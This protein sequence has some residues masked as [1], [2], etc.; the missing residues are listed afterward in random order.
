VSVRAVAVAPG[1]AL[2]DGDSANRINSLLDH[3]FAQLDAQLI[4]RG[5][6]WMIYEPKFLG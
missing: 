4:F 3:Q 5:R 6:L 1:F 2:R